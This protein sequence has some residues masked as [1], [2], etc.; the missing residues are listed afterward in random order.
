[1]KIV[2][3]PDSFKES[4]SADRV[5]E[6]I[7]AGLL[8]AWEALGPADDRLDVDMVPMADGGE[9][10]VRIVLA[11]AGGRLCKVRVTGPLSEPVE[12]E[13]GLLSDGRTAVIEMASAAGLHLVPEDRR[14]PTRTTTYGVG[15]LIRAA[16][17]AGATRIILG[18]GGSATTDGGVGCAQALGVRFIEASGRPLSR[19]L[20]G[21]DLP[22]IARID[23]TGRDERL[24]QVELLVACDVDNPLTG[25]AGAAA[26]YSPQKGATP[27]QVEM[28]DGALRHL[29]EL[30][31]RD[32]G[33]DVE[34]VE[35]AGAAGGLGAGLMAFCGAQ[36]RS[37]FECIAEAVGLAERMRGS[38]LCITA[39]GRIDAQ[40]VRGKVISGVGR[41]A[42]QMGVPCIALAGQL[43][44]GYDA[45]LQDVDAICCI[46]DRPCGLKEAIERT[47]RLLAAAAE[48][49]FRIF[50]SGRF[51]CG[52]GRP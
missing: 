5:A 40:S 38:S 51:P 41:L 24:R 26:V 52:T 29:A 34:H 9:G 20:A 10:T 48:Q 27:D 4:L 18:I 43:G 45:C 21:G 49:V 14:D 13:F 35:G 32:L 50:L 30:I 17:D 1:M 46:I 11:A 8:R 3:A 15:E 47:G 25:P 2:V 19:P 39:E 42:R 36:L 44:D 33:V 22:L 6:A 16:L 37:G 31:R 28:L 12:A 23:V 7:R